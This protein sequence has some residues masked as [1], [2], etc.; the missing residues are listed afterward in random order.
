MSST[1]SL[2]TPPFPRLVILRYLA[3][4]LDKEGNR[5]LANTKGLELAYSFFL[6]FQ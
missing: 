3:A 4:W 5:K 1:L 2:T 6:L